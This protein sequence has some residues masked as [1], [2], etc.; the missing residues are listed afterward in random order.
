LEATSNDLLQPVSFALENNVFTVFSDG[1]DCTGCPAD[2]GYSLVA[3][4]AAT[5][6]HQ[7]YRL[8][9]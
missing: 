6:H 1:R 8:L 2:S 3:G 7:Q 5:Q 9:N 4:H